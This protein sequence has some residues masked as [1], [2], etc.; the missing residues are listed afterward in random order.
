MTAATGT[1]PTALPKLGGYDFY[2]QVLKS[3][4]YV[5]APMVDQS[6]LAWRILSRRYDAQLVYTP[7]INAK[8]F[9]EDS[10]RGYRDQNFNIPL[11]EE[12]GPQDRPLI[13]QFCSNDPEKLLA[14]ALV[15][16]DHCDAVDLNLGCPQDI[17]RR[18]RYG[19]YLQDD[20][21]LIH[22]LIN[23]LHTNLRVPVTA[24]F[25][26]F[27][28]LEKTVEYA[29][30]LERAGAQILTCHGR[31]R[32]QRGSNTGLADWEKIAAVKRA[33]KVPVFAN[34]N[35]LYQEDIEACLKAT[36]ADG[37]MSA[38]GNLYNPALFAGLPSDS[39]LASGSRDHTTLA[40][41]YLEIVKSLKT[42]TAPSAVKGH[43]FKML[44]P[45][46]ARET[47]LRDRLGK[48]MQKGTGRGK[49]LRDRDW[50]D[51]YAQIV[52]EVQERMERDKAAALASEKPDVLPIPHWFAQ[53]YPTGRLSENLPGPEP[54]SGTSEFIDRPA[55][56]A[57][58]LEKAESQVALDGVLSGAKRP[59]T[60]SEP[61]ESKRPRL[62]TEE[63]NSA[64]AVSV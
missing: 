62:E 9:A 17:A 63:N 11:G 13:V 19:S 56:H 48:V 42:E 24:K 29:Q 47:D 51:D 31:T 34:G 27:P 45:A 41:E 6:E 28:S 4:K 5:V 55:N 21:D 49:G 14:S 1:Q 58:E 26:V 37:V 60:P 52:R 36:G 12:G 20:W 54:A 25:R 44:R 39:K 43:L 46:L 35:I 38:E 32:E 10:R 33:V 16:Q 64:P 40:L 57:A 15:V 7:M 3:P 61:V 59:P 22:N 50:V 2:R 53:P 18:G 23:I 30:M 8:L